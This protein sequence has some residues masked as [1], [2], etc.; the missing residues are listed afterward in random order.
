MKE[1]LLVTR[2][3]VIISIAI[4]IAY[5]VLTALIEVYHKQMIKKHRSSPSFSKTGVRL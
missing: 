2:T 1:E 3:S 5:F 4:I